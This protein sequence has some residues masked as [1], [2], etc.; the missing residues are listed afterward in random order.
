MKRSS[1]S[2]SAGPRLQTVLSLFLAHSLAL[3]PVSASPAQ[4]DDAVGRAPRP[5]A[6]DGA[7]LPNP[8]S[9]TAG[10]QASKGKV[11]GSLAAASFISTLVN[12]INTWQWSPPSPDP[13]A[14]VYIPG[15][16]TLLVSDSEVDEMAIYAGANLFMATRSGALVD[17]GTTFPSLS[18][19]PTGMAYN[20]TNGD[21]FISDDGPKRVF[22]IRAGADGRFGTA[23]D[24]LVSQLSTLAFNSADP[25]G[26]AFDSSGEGVLYIADGVNR[27]IYIV[28][29]G[30]N[31]LFDG[32][33]DVVTSFDT[34]R[35]GLQD[36]EGIAFN[37][38]SG[39]LYIVGTTAN[40]LFEVS[41]EG[42]LVQ[43]ID[44]SAANA[45][46][47]AGLEYA[48]GSQNPAQMNIYVVD[49]RVDNNTNPAENDGMMYELTLPLPPAGPVAPVGNDDSALI[50]QGTQVTLDVA[51]NDSDLN[52]NLNP[53]SANTAC[54]GCT[55]PLNGGLV[56][57]G[58]GTFTYT[59]DPGFLGPDSFVYE[60][61]DTDLQCST[62]RATITMFEQRTLYVT[63]TSGGSVAGVAFEDEDILA[64]D[65]STGSWSMFFDGSDVGLGALNQDINAFHINADGS[66]L[67]SLALPEDTLPGV[68]IVED[69]DIL[70]F[71]PIST[72]VDTAGSFEWYFDG[73]DVELTENGEDIDAIGFAPDGRLLLSVSG[74]YSVTGITGSSGDEDLIAFTPVS[75]GENTSGSWELYFDGSDVGLND[76]VDEDVNGAWIDASGNIF[77]TTAGPFLVTG[78]AGEATDIFTCVPI[79]VGASTRCTFSPAWDG[80][81]YGFGSEILDGFAF[82][83]A[84]APSNQTPLVDAGPDQALT[85][86]S[87]ANLDGTVTDDGLPNPPA[88]VT[89]TWS[90]TSGPGTVSFADAGAVVTTA[91]FPAAG[92]Y[93]L[94]LTADDSASSAFDEL[95]V[96]VAQANQAPSVSAGP[97]Q[98]VTLPNAASLD[99]TVTDDGLPNPPALVTTTWS[100]TSGP[101]TVTFANAGAVD[102]TASFSAAGTYVLRLTADDSALSAFDELTI[103]VDPAGGTSTAIDLGAAGDFTVLGLNGA[104]ILM[105]YDYPRVNG[106][107]GLGPNGERELKQGLIAGTFFMDP[108][109]ITKANSIS[110]QGTTVVTSMASVVADALRAS[111][112]ASNL[113]A[114]QTFGDIKDAR[115][116]QATAGLN[117]VD[118]KKIELNGKTL[119]LQGGP[120]DVFVINILDNLKLENGSRIQLAGGVQAANVLF[121][122]EKKKAKGEIK[123]GSSA[124]GTF[125][126]TGQDAELKIEDRGSTVVGAL[127]A[128]KKV[129]IKKDAQVTFFGQ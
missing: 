43:T 103:T 9:Q 38:D 15:S 24:P 37:P 94:R 42:N 81:L 87:I 46:N 27:E 35:L 59:P 45:L 22:V 129:E 104:T 92:T 13:A 73:S 12:T 72:G 120:G 115:T 18:D 64:Y 16:D 53:S 95:T 50:L 90:Q 47:A 86:P 3:T 2:I 117:V 65:I 119:T 85:L 98:T 70:R 123:S 48:P 63:S 40:T 76:T 5:L 112:D 69:S 49:R 30:S 25:E 100:Q 62:A 26:L 105:K 66:I 56:D 96:T 68:G 32:V 97:D 75:L 21:L 14:V 51:A 19:E 11:A 33:D 84:P 55:S 89:T 17:T 114:T 126:A 111:S 108:T 8:A 109:A 78:A 107:V 91:S 88:T 54:A 23:D 80:S 121:N 44:I 99:G 36:P 28:I 128:G 82:W 10:P 1:K 52:G 34:A 101:G 93:V 29:P 4:K 67:L 102:T 124:S 118:V 61:C 122:F 127:I 31:G 41:T 125:L 20:P 79:S 83:T 116:I 110:I 106:D 71:V 39:H 58:D 74:T 60:I 113:A 77:L 7:G 57:H 6:A